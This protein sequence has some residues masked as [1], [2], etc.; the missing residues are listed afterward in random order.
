M[1]GK[2]AFVFKGKVTT[3]LQKILIFL[4]ILSLI[5]YYIFDA[6]TI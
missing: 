3:L 6:I 4:A 2:Q 5:L 1:K